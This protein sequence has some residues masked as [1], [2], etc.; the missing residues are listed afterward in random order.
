[1]TEE[2]PLLP[3]PTTGDAAGTG[4]ATSWEELTQANGRH[5]L[6]DAVAMIHKHNQDMGLDEKLP[7]LPTPKAH[8]GVFGT[9]RTS[10]RP[11]EKSTHLGTIVSLMGIPDDPPVKLLPT[12]TTSDSRG[13]S[14]GGA[15]DENVRVPRLAAAMEVD[16]PRELAEED[17]LLPTPLAA[18]GG[19]SHGYGMRNWAQEYASGDAP[20]LPTPVA[21]DSLGNRN[22][23]ANRKSEPPSGVRRWDTLTD[24]VTKIEHGLDPHVVAP[25]A[26]DGAGGAVPLLPTPTQSD[27][28]G[29]G[30]RTGLSWEGTTKPTGQGGNSRLRDVVGLFADDNK[31]V[32]MTETPNTR[33]KT[34]SGPTVRQAVDLTQGTLP[35][36]F[37]S[38][39]EV[40]D[41]WRPLVKDGGGKPETV[42]SNADWVVTDRGDQMFPTP[43]AADGHR[44]GTDPD[45]TKAA[46]HRVKLIDAVL[47]DDLREPAGDSPLLP[48]PRAGA[49]DGT[50]S[51]PDQRR[52][53]GQS[54]SL[55]EAVGAEMAPLLPTPVAQDGN[56]H[57]QDP[58]A[59]VGN[60]GRSVSLGDVVSRL[61]EGKGSLLPTPTVGASLVRNSP[62]E[63]ARTNPALGAVIADL[64]EAEVAGEAGVL[65]PTPKTH[66]RGDCPSERERNS[67][68]LAAVTGHFPAGRWGKYG[69]AV[70]RWESLTRPAPAP[71]EPN[72]NGNPR[73][74]ARFSEWLI[75]WPEGWVSDPEIGVSRTG[76][77]RIVGNGVVPQQA[78]AAIS[79]LL[80]NLD[81]PAPDDED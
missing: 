15:H 58:A 57:M 3:T 73:L 31:E 43:S 19:G 25:M 2:D 18:D 5:R 9:P 32:P 4:Y 45:R 30:I 67:P 41:E 47:G 52:A 79:M 22:T 36:E 35:L 69:P 74:T 80:K 7:L 55:S 40:P 77:L 71:T 75:G 1:M 12:P 64:A 63:M 54:V 6:R 78:Y 46:G 68:D 65:L 50:A 13:A 62:G 39:D 51:T 56:G 72:K 28:S 66:Q 48:T 16:L 33:R 61:P 17:A 53:K 60:N 10:G 20:L 38:W 70:A 81:V 21:G 59:D 42:D 34:D 29:G 24:A 14:S 11:I 8:D 76:Q 37:D 26:S 23:T 49:S 44:G 27:G